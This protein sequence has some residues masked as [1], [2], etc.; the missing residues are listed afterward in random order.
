MYIAI[1]MLLFIAIPKCAGTSTISL[2]YNKINMK[3]YIKKQHLIGSTV[4]Y[5]YPRNNFKNDTHA[6][7]SH[8][9][10]KT[11]QDLDI[12]DQNYYNSSFKFCFVRNPWDR[13]VSLFFYQKL[14]TIFNSFGEFITYL[15]NNR[16]II[17]NIDDDYGNTFLNTSRITLP[18]SGSAWNQ[19]VDWIPEDI[20]FVGRFENYEEDLKK[21][22]KILNIN[23][24]DIY[25]TNKTNHRNY[26]EYY[27][28]ETKQMVAELYKDDIERFNYTY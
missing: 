9:N 14:D 20:N 1:N 7:F 25:H 27:N 17:P 16:S 11:L 5:L 6:C 10:V 8:A 13:A 3:T 28:E 18:I 12:I 15:Y 19:M 4:P 2:L 21:L 26:R 23:C 24:D 22:F